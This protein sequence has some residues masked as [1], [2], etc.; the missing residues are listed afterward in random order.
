VRLSLAP[1][2]CITLDQ[3]VKTSTSLL[4][5]AACGVALV[6]YGDRK[7]EKIEKKKISMAH[8]L[9]DNLVLLS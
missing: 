6:A 4:N 9:G 3:R 2:R 8:G 5:L 1:F 7:K